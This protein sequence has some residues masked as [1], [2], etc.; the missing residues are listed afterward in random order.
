MPY[1]RQAQR[2][3]LENILHLFMQNMPSDAGELNYVISRICDI[4]IQVKGKNYANLNEVMGVMECAKNE[5]YRR[6]VAPYE[7]EKINSNGD[8]YGVM[9]EKKVN[10]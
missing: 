4:Y 2:N 9:P 1:I 5:Y 8:V 10:Q 6:V 3:R 7:N